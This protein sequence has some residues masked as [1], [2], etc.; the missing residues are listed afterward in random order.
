MLCRSPW[1]YVGKR[2]MEAALKK[3]EGKLS[4]DIYWHPFQLNA[5][6]SKTGVNKMQLYN[7]KFGAERVAAMLPAM[8]VRAARVQGVVYA[9]S[10][11]FAKFLSRLAPSYLCSARPLFTSWHVIATLLTGGLS[12]CRSRYVPLVPQRTSATP[13]LTTACS[14]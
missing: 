2:R 3:Y 12:R 8:R 5:D 14:A 11:E 4:F 6:A 13:H 7:E 1:C 9:K 10:V